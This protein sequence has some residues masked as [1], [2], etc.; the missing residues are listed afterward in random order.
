MPRHIWG[1]KSKGMMENKRK[2]NRSLILLAL[3]A[4]ILC[5]S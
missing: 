5:A 1:C 2:N 4:M 3:F